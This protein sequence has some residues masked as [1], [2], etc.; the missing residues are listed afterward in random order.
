MQKMFEDV[1]RRFEI[2]YHNLCLGTL[3]LD[4]FRD[5]NFH[6]KQMSS[7][8]DEEFETIAVDLG[9]SDVAM[10]EFFGVSTYAVRKRRKEI[11]IPRGSAMLNRWFHSGRE[12]VDIS[13]FIKQISA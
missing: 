11:G 9:F 7:L 4:D 13:P 2:W 8:T 10:S 6:P 1:N 5:G 3:L 12:E